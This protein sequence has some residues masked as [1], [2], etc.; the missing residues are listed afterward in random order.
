MV[1][2]MGAIS[3]TIGAMGVMALSLALAGLYGLVV[4][5]VSTRTR[6]I[7][8]RMALGADRGAVLRMVLRHGFTL[9]VA[10]IVAGVGLGLGAGRLLEASSPGDNSDLGDLS[11]STAVMVFVV[12]VL[13]MLAA[14]IPARRATRVDP[15]VALR[16]E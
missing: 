3:R 14:Y 8:V 13:T 5:S 7:G 15:N 10:G 6:E 1:G 9:A 16:C 11:N 4:Y 2:Y 12:L